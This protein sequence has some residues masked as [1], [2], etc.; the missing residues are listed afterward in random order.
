MTNALDNIFYTKCVDEIDMEA[1]LAATPVADLFMM[2]AS[3]GV[4]LSSLL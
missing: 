3:A 4:V 1:D 2:G